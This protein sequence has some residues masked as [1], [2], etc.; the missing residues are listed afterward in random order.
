M[1]TDRHINFGQR[2]THIG[3]GAARRCLVIRALH[4]V[5]LAATLSVLSATG[6]IAEP[7][8]DIVDACTQT[9]SSFSKIK[10]F[11][12]EKGWNAPDNLPENEAGAQLS[13][14]QVGANVNASS[15]DAIWKN[16]MQLRSESAAAMVGKPNSD[17]YQSELLQRDVEGLRS[18]LLVSSFTA[19]SGAVQIHCQFAGHGE[20]NPETIS[21]IRNQMAGVAAPDAEIIYL[22]GPLSP[23]VDGAQTGRINIT[24]LDRKK[25]EEKLGY[26]VTA[27]F[28][29]ETKLTIRPN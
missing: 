27:D 23:K 2:P 8:D 21:W 7:A 5:V 25:V 15:S 1:P 19:D 17:F 14:A 13:V 24:V 10:A 3:S 28:G 4:H 16:A 20:N 26:D 22:N 29:V 11:L 9:S 18:L 12:S 6:A